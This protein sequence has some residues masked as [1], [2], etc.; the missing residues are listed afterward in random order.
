[1]GELENRS[2]RRGRE[3]RWAATGRLLERDRPC[4]ELV[5]CMGLKKGRVGLKGR[6]ADAAHKSETAHCLMQ[7][8]CRLAALLAPTF[9]L[10]LFGRL[11]SS[12]FPLSLSLSLSLFA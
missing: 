12:T 5:S 2:R 11:D 8:T 10:W 3:Q 1:M 9:G 4:C 6:D 7:P